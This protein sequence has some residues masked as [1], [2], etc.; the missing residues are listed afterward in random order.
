MRMKETG[1]EAIPCVDLTISPLGLSLENE[2]PVPPPDWCIRAIYFRASK[3]PLI[4]SSTGSTKHAE[5]CPIGVPAFMSVG[6]LG[7][8]CNEA[9]RL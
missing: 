8:K 4:E 1:P 2:K 7:R 6:E 9:I 5:S 3:I